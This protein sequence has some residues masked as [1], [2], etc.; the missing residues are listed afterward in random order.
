VTLSP[1][2]TDALLDQGETRMGLARAQLLVMVAKS[3]TVRHLAGHRQ[4]KDLFVLK[5]GTLLSNVYRSPRQSIA[6]ADYTYLDPENL[7]VPDLEQALATD[8]EYGF[9]LH[10]EEGRWTT[11]NELFEGQTPFTMEGIKLGRRKSD[12]QLKI[13]VSVRAGEWLDPVAPLIYSDLL[14]AD[15]N[16]FSVNGLSREELSAEKLLG[17][18]SKPL[19]KHLVDLACVARDHAEEVDLAKVA[20]LVGEKFEAEKSAPRYQGAGIRELSDLREALSREQKLEE[21]REDWPRFAE[22]ELLPLPSEIAKGEEDTLSRVENVERL[23]I[24]FWGPM[25]DQLG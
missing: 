18:C 21:L 4:Y 14:L 7:T 2:T 15:D 25:L 5:G 6:D 13:S 22:G 17:W 19:P 23:A 12:H 10:P 3:A 11:A 8:G 24:G 16:V 9:E 1:V 20:D